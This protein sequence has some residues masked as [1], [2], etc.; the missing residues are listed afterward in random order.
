VRYQWAAHSPWPKQA[1]WRSGSG[2]T[3][4]LHEIVY[5][6]FYGVIRSRKP[7]TR[8]SQVLR[9]VGQEALVGGPRAGRGGAVADTI[10]A[11]AVDWRAVAKGERFWKSAAVSGTGAKTDAHK[12]QSKPAV[13]AT[14]PS[15]ASVWTSF[16]PPPAAQMTCMLPGLMSDEAIADPRNS[17]N[18]AS[19]R[20]AIS[21]ELRRCAISTLSH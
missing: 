12:G 4:D 21:F 19:T 16:I 17:A 2:K 5:P 9:T 3:T 20:R 11:A 1:A 6:A 15:P 7:D 14:L 18:N 13:I 10:R 8:E